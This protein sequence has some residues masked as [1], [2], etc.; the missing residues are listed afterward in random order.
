MP[1]PIQAVE[2]AGARWWAARVPTGVCA[3]R[4]GAVRPVSATVSR[5]RR[6]G[7]AVRG[8]PGERVGDQEG[9]MRCGELGGEHIGGAAGVGVIGDESG[10]GHCSSGDV[11]MPMTNQTASNAG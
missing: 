5:G 1:W 11:A 10:G 3:G 7:R 2:G 4:C 9:G 8:D 6:A